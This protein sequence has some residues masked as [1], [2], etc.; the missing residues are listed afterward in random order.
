MTKWVPVMVRLEDY[1]DFT[2]QVAAREAQRPEEPAES[3]HVTTGMTQ[4]GAKGEQE[5]AL[6]RTWSLEDLRRIDETAHAFK[7]MDRWARALDAVSERPG[8]DGWMS[9]AEVADATGMS[10]NEWRDAPRKLPQHLKAHF[11]EGI[12]WP[13]KAL[14]GRWLG[15]DD[16]VYW[17]I[18]VEQARR[19]KQVR[20]ASREV[21][22]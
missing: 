2:S 1:A 19:W 18:T 12:E 11:P 9:T 4:R 20:A 14:S 22:Q 6:L 10:I 13:L 17:G 8:P 7:T 3:P 15:K 5:L 21:D 16:Q